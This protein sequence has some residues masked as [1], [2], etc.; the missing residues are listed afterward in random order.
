MRQQHICKHEISPPFHNIFI[1][2]IG[3]IILQVSLVILAVEYTRWR[4]RKKK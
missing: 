4:D 3:A 1:M 2:E